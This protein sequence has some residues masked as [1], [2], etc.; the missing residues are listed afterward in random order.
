MQSLTFPVSCPQCGAGYA[1]HSVC[2]NRCGTARPGVDPIKVQ[3]V[4][5]PDERPP[6]PAAGL[7]LAVAF[8]VL[9]QL[10][11]GT[12]YAAC[13][14]VLIW[15]TMPKTDSWHIFYCVEGV[16][17]ALVWASW[18]MAKADSGQYQVK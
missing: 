6:M 12:M 16:F 9:V 4:A 11:I 2:C 13:A 7:S 18:V 1:P 14:S 8:A 3:I 17:L 15:F 5:P 10:V